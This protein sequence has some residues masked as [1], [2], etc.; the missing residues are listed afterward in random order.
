[1]GARRS[2]CKMCGKGRKAC[3]PESSP[4]THSLGV[5]GKR[6]MVQNK[7]LQAFV[8]HVGIDLGR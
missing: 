6:V 7:L 4:V 5:A 2:G 1:M 8:Q 3:G